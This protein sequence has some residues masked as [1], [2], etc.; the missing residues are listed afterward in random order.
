LPA[1]ADIDRVQDRDAIDAV[2][3]DAAGADATTQKWWTDLR[4]KLPSATFVVLAGEL[5][6]LAAA[7]RV[8]SSWELVQTC[9]D[10]R[11]LMRVVRY[12]A[13]RRRLQERMQAMARRHRAL[14]ENAV[15]VIAVLGIDGSCVYASPAAERLFGDAPPLV[16]SRF[17]DRVHIDDVLPMQALTLAVATDPY[18][19]RRCELRVADRD[20][21]WRML[22]AT[23]C[24]L[25]DGTQKQILIN[26][27]DISE[28]RESERALQLREQEF[29]QAEKMDA[30]G[31]LAGGVAHDFSNVLTVILGATERLLESV[32]AGSAA[33]AQ[34]ESIRAAA[35]PAVALTTQLLTFSR[36]Q[37][38]VPAVLS[39]SEVMSGVGRFLQPMIGEHV[40]LSVVVKPGAGSIRANRTQIEQVLLNL[41]INARDAMPDGG[42]LTMEARASKFHAERSVGGIL[43]PPGPYVV[44]RVEDS[45]V[46]MDAATQAR[47]F[48]PYFTTKGPSKGSGIGLA[49]VYGIVSQSGGAV[50]LNS[51]KSVGTT[52]LIY[53]PQVEDLREA[54]PAVVATRQAAGGNETVLLVEDQNEVRF[55]VRDMLVHAGYTVLDADCPQVA[56]NICREHTGIIHL[57]LTDVV[58]PRG[59][60]W[61][62][63]QHVAAA[64]ADTRVLFMSGYP[65]HPGSSS[66]MSSFEGCEYLAKPFNRQQLLTRVREVLDRTQVQHVDGR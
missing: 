19:L 56:E 49:T 7:E 55:L 6:D 44:I 65:E 52:I 5:Q 46:G 9:D 36:R 63:A 50:A 18:A 38:A 8:P 31:R 59:N 39:V 2:L 34:A 48:E 41:A 22:E 66:K 60:G 43:L 61:D 4:R 64:R 17:W 32:P 47:A 25:M 11:E 10:C 37:A 51:R 16:G 54:K 33:R 42:R 20:G 58:M 27:H 29:L 15:D 62:L 12:A 1:R 28:R 23:V 14:L 53:L 40:E 30:I 45:G 35:E 3:L 26:A 57:L 21:A 24:L 13:E